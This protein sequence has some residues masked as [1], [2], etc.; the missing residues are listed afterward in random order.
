VIQAG[1]RMP[2]EEQ[3]YASSYE[4]DGKHFWKNEK[5]PEEDWPEDHLMATF[6]FTIAKRRLGVMLDQPEADELMEKVVFKRY[7]DPNRDRNMELP[8]KKKKNWTIYFL[9]GLGIITWQVLKR[10]LK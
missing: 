2:E 5:F 7:N 8:T 9:V 1:K 4:I 10:R 6:S 3:I